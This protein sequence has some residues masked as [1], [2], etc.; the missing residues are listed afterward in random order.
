MIIVVLQAGI[1][2]IPGFNQ[3]FLTAIEKELQ[4]ALTK[5]TLTPLSSTVDLGNIPSSILFR[6]SN[7]RQYSLVNKGKADRNFRYGTNKN[8]ILNTD[9]KR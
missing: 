8:T 6:E 9:P 3:K 1:N 7:W 2:G 5:G 4:Q